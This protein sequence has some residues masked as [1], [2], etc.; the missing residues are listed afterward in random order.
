[1]ASPDVGYGRRTLVFIAVAVLIAAHVLWQAWAIGAAPYPARYDYDEG[2]YA[3]T[4]AVSAGYRL[5]Q[6]VF[7]SQPPLLIEVLRRAFDLFGRSLETARGVVVAFSALWLAAL[8]AAAARAGGHRAALW[9]VV[10]AGSAP[11]FALAAHTVQMEAPSEALAASAVALALTAGGA[12]SKD[13]LARAAGWLWAGTGAAAG[14]AVMTKFTAATCLVPIAVIALVGSGRPSAG[15]AAFRTAALGAG[16]AAAAAA[17]MLWT[18]SPPGAMWHQAVEFHSAVARVTAVDPT[19][20]ASLLLGFGLANWLLVLVGLGGLVSAGTA[21]RGGRVPGDHAARWAIAAWLGTDLAAAFL[22]RPVWPH[23]LVILV[24]PLALLGGTA[25]ETWAPSPQNSGTSPVIRGAGGAI[26]IV[27]WL[28]ALMGTAAAI[29]PET[30]STLRAAAAATARRVPPGGW[31]VADDPIVPFLAGRDVPPQLCDTSEMRT[32]AG[33]ITEGD[34]TAA[35]ADPRVRALVL[36]RGTFRRAFP[37]F[38]ARASRA[39][40]VRW[41]AGDERVILAR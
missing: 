36:W 11:A 24:A 6:T 18:G 16:G 34:L 1:M 5:Y 41:N 40:S 31:V 29:M 8:A 32:G 23:H 30:S 20:T 21:R 25:I 7:L 17:A 10:I 13:G 14:L 15:A 12:S 26:L 9:V 38:V 2:V 37:G 27:A 35:L 19:R 28:A 22:W 4:A 33:W 3:E 39:L